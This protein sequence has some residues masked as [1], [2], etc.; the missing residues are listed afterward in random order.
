[1]P[2]ATRPST[3]RIKSAL[4]PL[5]IGLRHIAIASHHIKTAGWRV[6]KLLQIALRRQ[7]NAALLDCAHTGCRAALRRANTLAHLYKHQRTIGSTHNGINLAATAPRGFIVT[8][9][10]LQTLPLQKSYGA[11]LCRIAALLAAGRC[12]GKG[13]SAML[14]RITSITITAARRNAP[15][16][17]TNLP[18]QT[19]NRIAPQVNT[20]TPPAHT[21]ASATAAESTSA[22]TA[23]A[24]TAASNAPQRPL[25]LQAAQAAAGAQ[26]YPAGSLYLVA[27]PIGNLADITLRALHVLQRV[28]A[29]ACEDT[30]H[31]Q[32]LLRAYGLERPA[33]QLIA[34]HQHNEQQ[35]AQQVVSLL[36]QGARIAYVSDAGTP[37][38][39]DP[40]TQL[41]QAVQGAGLR[42]IPLPGASS[43]I[44][45]LCASG[46]DTTLHSNGIAGLGGGWLF[47]GFLPTKGAER[48]RTLQAL[49]AE[50]RSVVLL[51]APHRI[52]ALCTALAAALGT[53]HVTLAR[54]LTKQFEHIHTLP[55]AQLPEWIA[56]APEHSKGE[57]V[58]V[59]HPLPPA[60][61]TNSAH[62]PE[63]DRILHLLL[64]ELPTKAAVKLAAEITG[65][66]RNALYDRALQIKAPS[67]N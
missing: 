16:A 9:Q 3:T 27:T 32:S 48:Q 28:D 17:L 49:Q 38:I 52:A 1:M 62:N 11:C 45:A 58:V 19:H 54:E 21:A 33:K 57:F 59:L 6:G 53:R 30:R 34:L 44:T 4:Q 36:Q 39:S 60:S 10:Q 7:H 14:P 23:S 37:C 25:L 63:H 65:A 43:I 35:A 42:V 13:C 15:Q 29:I 26:S 20:P 66:P 56:A 55:A 47:G 8:L 61:D 46:A 12:S 41:V 67:G 40:G 50:P 2:V 18:K 51:E 31:T 24:C 22:N 64:A 5:P